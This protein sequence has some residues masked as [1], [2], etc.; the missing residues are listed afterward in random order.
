MYVVGH[1]QNPGTSTTS[2]VLIKWDPDGNET[3]SRT[4]NH[5]YNARGRGIWLNESNVVVA[6]TVTNQEASR[7][8]IAL[9]QYDV[10]GTLKWARV[11]ETLGNERVFGTWGT[12]EGIYTAGYVESTSGTSADGLLVKWS[13]DGIRL[14]QH[15]WGHP[16]WDEG[17]GAWGNGSTVYIAGSSEGNDGVSGMVLVKQVPSVAPPAPA[18]VVALPGTGLPP[19]AGTRREARG[20]RWKR[21]SCTGGLK[22]TRTSRG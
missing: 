4:W 3:W 19:S 14:W 5:A 17:R 1:T 8:G 6:G 13:T 20:R 22:K 10:W 15:S 11:P 7:A 12:S 18:G 21:T 2:M 9:V 16:G